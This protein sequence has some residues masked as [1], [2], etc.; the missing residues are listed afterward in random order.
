MV[1]VIFAE[2]Q[3]IE[4]HM[5]AKAIQWADECPDDEIYWIRDQ[6]LEKVPNVDVDLS[7]KMDA[8]KRIKFMYNRTKASVVCTNMALDESADVAAILCSMPKSIR[9]DQF[10]ICLA[11]LA[12]FCNRNGG[13][14][15]AVVELWKEVLFACNR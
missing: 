4:D 2:S 9:C 5:F 3:K 12:H 8:L 15:V 7:G 14:A 6:A 10:G 13:K 1:T 11:S